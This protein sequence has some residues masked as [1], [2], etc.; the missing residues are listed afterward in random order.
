MIDVTQAVEDILELGTK[1]LLEGSSPREVAAAFERIAGAMHEAATA[2]D[3]MPREVAL[4]SLRK[5]FRDALAG[6][7]R[8][9][10]DPQPGDCLR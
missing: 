1:A 5:T 4:A 7:T 10:P 2:L 6:K 8:P 3:P 9:R